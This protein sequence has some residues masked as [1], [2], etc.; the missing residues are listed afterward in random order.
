MNLYKNEFINALTVG[1]QEVIKKI[2]KIDP[3]NKLKGHAFR[4]Q[5][6]AKEKYVVDVFGCAAGIIGTCDQLKYVPVLMQSYKKKKTFASVGLTNPK[7][8]QY[9]LE[10]HYIKIATVLDQ[11][12]I[13]IGKVYDLGIPE[14][15][16]TVEAILKNK[17]TQNGLPA[18]LVKAFD[19]S[20]EGI[21]SVRN[22]IVHR[23][24]FCDEEIRHISTW[25]FLLETGSDIFTDEDVKFET[26]MVL[27][28]KV[29]TV[30]GN[31]TTVERLVWKC[32][33]ALEKEF[34]RHAEVLTKV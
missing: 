31:N 30:S 32:F 23:G 12:A 16:C 1:M 28:T 5:L 18:S 24:E 17:H 6:S 19:K 7:Y 4:K 8:I 2:H 29:Q 22:L 34:R 21:K 15:Y 9:H 14:K 33:D 3:G 27:K 25:Q 10:V 20:I 26:K 13:L 11:M